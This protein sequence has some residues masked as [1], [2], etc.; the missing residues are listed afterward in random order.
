MRSTRVPVHL[1]SPV[2]RSRPSN[3]SSSSEAAFHVRAH[4]EQ[5]HK[6]VIGERLWPLG[7]DA[8]LGLSEVGIQD[9]HA[10]N[11]NRHFRCGQGQ[12][13][14]PVNQQFLGR[15]GIFGLQVVA[16]TVRFRLEHGEGGHIGLLLRGVHA[17][18]REGNRHRVTGILRRLLDACATAQNDQV[19][20]RDL[21]AAG[22]CAVERA[23]DALQGLAAPSPTGQA[24]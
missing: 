24:D 19:S 1:S 10:A 15:Y 21:L 4:V 5:V 20:Q 7:E 16:E 18:R 17:S 22:L 3:T 2:L 6:E 8:V 9:A 11:K 14:R 23:L 13:L 12:Q